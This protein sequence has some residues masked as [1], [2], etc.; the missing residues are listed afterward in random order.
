MRRITGAIL[1]EIRPESM[2]VSAWRGV[3]RAAS[4]PKRAMS[5]R[6]PMC[7]IHSLAHL[8]RQPALVRVAL[9]ALRAVAGE[10]LPEQ[11]VDGRE[12]QPEDRAEAQEDERREIGT[13][14]P[15]RIC[16]TACAEVLLSDIR[17]QRAAH[18]H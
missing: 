17:H 15:A 7:D 8:G 5:M 12:D 13:D 16:T 6:G 11:R 4:K 10:V 2:I 3:A 18:S 9:R 14:H 1:I